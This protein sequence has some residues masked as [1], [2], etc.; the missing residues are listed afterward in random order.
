M[1]HLER[2]YNFYHLREDKKFLDGN[3]VTKNSLVREVEA[4]GKDGLVYV[5]SIETDVKRLFWI[6]QD[7]LEFEC[8]MVPDITSEEWVMMHE[9][10]EE[11]WETWKNLKN[12]LKEKIDR[13]ARAGTVRPGAGSEQ[14]SKKKNK[15]S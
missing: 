10:Q 1:E 7:V 13:K 14:K 4:A 2:E 5:E 3:I 11:D 12:E 9:D 8:R 15:R 6:H